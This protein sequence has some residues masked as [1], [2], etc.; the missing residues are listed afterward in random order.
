MSIEWHIDALF[1]SIMQ[2]VHWLQHQSCTCGTQRVSLHRQLP[3]SYLLCFWPMC[4]C[5]W[6]INY[7]Q[8]STCLQHARDLDEILGKNFLY[9]EF[10]S[11]KL[12]SLI[13]YTDNSSTDNEN[14]R[15][16]LK[17]AILLQLTS[18]WLCALGLETP[19]MAYDHCLMTA[20]SVV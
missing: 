17:R 5:G 3:H 2:V 16:I 7:P 11:Q 18:C 4:W 9:R 19:T 13:S 1:V 14:T 20:V 15:I 8:A 12:T 6:C 10:F